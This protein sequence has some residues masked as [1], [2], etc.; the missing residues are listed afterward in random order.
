MPVT[1]HV[2]IMWN[3]KLVH[4]ISYFLL[5]M[6]LDFSWQSGKHLLFKGCLILIYSSMIEFGQSFVPGREMSA[7]DV[8]ANTTGIL[9][10]I[11]LV[12]ILKKVS[13]Y[14]FLRIEE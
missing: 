2:P 5:M 6:M 11:F 4:F 14:Q 12:P 10:Y 7:G 9:L 13:A 1:N 3:D 8:A